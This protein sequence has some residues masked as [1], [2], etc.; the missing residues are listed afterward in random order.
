VT[1]QVALLRGI[2]VGGNKKLPMADLRAFCARAGYGEARTL[3]QSGNLVLDAGKLKGAAL[4]QKLCAEIEAEFGFR[5]E[6]FVRDG[7]ELAAVIA[8]NPYPDFAKADPSHLVV[9][10]LKAAP[11]AAHVKAMNAV[12]EGPEQIRA[13]GR[14]VYITFPMGIADSRLKLPVEGTMR[15]W[16]TVTKLAAMVS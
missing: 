1:L 15:N 4:E 6:I 9:T 12:R 13:E 7:K 11:S 5:T 16:N 10:F 8:A 2:N 14:H 3:L